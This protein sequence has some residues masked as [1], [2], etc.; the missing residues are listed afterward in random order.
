MSPTIQ[1]TA[2]TQV[3][4][5]V[6]GGQLD[7]VLERDMKVSVGGQQVNVTSRALAAPADRFENRFVIA[8]TLVS[9]FDYLPSHRLARQRTA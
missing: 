7:S 8:D 1:I 9:P 4:L 5:T 2:K 6:V 3:T